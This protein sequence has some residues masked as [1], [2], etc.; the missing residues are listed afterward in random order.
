[1]TVTTVFGADAGA[2]VAVMLM[3]GWHDVKP[4]SFAVT[5][6]RTRDWTMDNRDVYGVGNFAFTEPDGAVLRGPLASVLAIRTRPRR[7][8]ASVL[9]EGAAG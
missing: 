1:M 6:H 4:G 5:A 9:T 3:D 2:V 8:L 7:T